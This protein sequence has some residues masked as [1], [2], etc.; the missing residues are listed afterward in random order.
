MYSKTTII[1]NLGKDP[2][3]KFTPNGIAVTSFSVATTTRVSK[4]KTPECPDG[5]K[6]SHNG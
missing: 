5:W 6:A 2:V 1:G 4:D 3:M